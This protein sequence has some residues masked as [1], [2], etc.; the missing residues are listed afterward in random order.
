LLESGLTTREIAQKVGC[1]S[2][3][4]ISRLK[5]K[6]E[7]TGNVKNKLG[8][9]R[10]RKLNERDERSVIRRLMTKECSNAVQL[11]KSLKTSNNIEVST[12]TI[13]KALK[14]NGLIAQVK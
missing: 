9:G 5:K 2:H 10:P 3:T 1:K 11:Q 12:N 7:E 4:T 6:Y 13:Y 8:S 14:R